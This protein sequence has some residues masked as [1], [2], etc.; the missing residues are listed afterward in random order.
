MTPPENESISMSSVV[1]AEP[2]Q[3]SVDMGEET[4]ILHLETGGYYSL[5]KVAS[6]IWQ[7]LQ[8]PVLVSEIGGVLSGEYGISR[9]RC[10]ADLLELLGE[11]EERGLV[12]VVSDKE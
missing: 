9:E 5:K 1:V 7:L 2:R 12:K 4:L 11:L 10:D 6:R 8:S 3:V